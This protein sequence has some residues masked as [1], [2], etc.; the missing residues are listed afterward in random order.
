MTYHTT[1]RLPLFYASFGRQKV[2]PGPLVIIVLA[3]AHVDQVQEVL[4]LDEREVRPVYKGFE[5][6]NRMAFLPIFVPHSQY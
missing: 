1:A 5:S 2:V 6:P 3:W 4:R